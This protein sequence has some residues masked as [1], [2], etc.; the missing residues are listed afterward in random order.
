MKKI[1]NGLLAVALVAGFTSC[2]K[3]LDIEKH[4]NFGTIEDFY[5]TDA[6]AEQ[7][8]A[9]MYLQWRDMTLNEF[10]VK[11]LMSD[12]IWCGGGGRGDVGTMEAL[13]E[14]THGTENPYAQ[15]F[16]EEYYKVIYKANLILTYVANDSQVKNRDRAE[17]LVARGYCH[18]MLGI[19]FGNAPVV[20]EILTG[21]K[22]RPVPSKEGELYEQAIK[23]LQDAI[24]SGCLTQKSGLDDSNANNRITLD[25]AKALLGKAY[26]FNGQN[27]AAADILD[28]VIDSHLYDLLP[29]EEYEN[30]HHAVA[31]NCRENILEFQKRDNNALIWNEYIG[32]TIELMSGWRADYLVYEPGSQAEIDRGG[33]SSYGFMNP[34]G[35]LWEAFKAMNPAMDDARRL[36]SIRDWSELNAYGITMI[37]GNAFYGNEGYFYW[38]HRMIRE[39]CSDPYGMAGY[40][41]TQFNNMKVMRFA[42]VLLLAAEAHNGDGKSLDYLNLVH[43]RAGLP[44]LTAYSLEALK[45]EKRLELCMEGTRFEDLVRWG[46]AATVLKDQGKKCPRFTAEGVLE[47]PSQWDK[48]NAGFKAGKHEHLPIPQTEMDINNN[49]EQHTGW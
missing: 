16:Y 13:N 20:T 28:Q 3:D 41:V 49:M 15:Q 26:M 36:A 46:D 40:Q 6:D 12:D 22:V 9:S 45:A 25:A 21:D 37:A 23:D 47:W 48:S 27:G 2:N 14:F 42:E 35:S 4:G 5:K 18:L 1:V 7:A 43:E 19:Y 17:A 38:K 33:T 11:N 44:K 31:N 30:L 34:T 24:S 8:T 29:T 39:D 32:N 10:F